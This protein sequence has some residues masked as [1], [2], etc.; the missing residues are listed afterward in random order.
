MVVRETSANLVELVVILCTRN[1]SHRHVLSAIR[2]DP[3]ATLQQ[4]R[5]LLQKEIASLPAQYSFLRLVGGHVVQI[6]AE[7]ESGPKAYKTKHFLPPVAAKPHLLL[8][9]RA[10]P[11]GPRNK[12]SQPAPA[13]EQLVEFCVRRLVEGKQYHHENEPGEIVGMIRLSPQA[14]LPQIR[15]DLATQLL[16]SNRY[17]FVRLLDGQVTLLTTAQEENAHPQTSLRASHFAPPYTARPEIV[18]LA[19]KTYVEG[20]VVPDETKTRELKSLASA[21]QSHSRVKGRNPRDMVKDKAAT[22]INAFLNS[23]GGVLLMGASDDGVIER[24]PIAGMKDN[25]EASLADRVALARTVKDDIRKLVDGICIQMDPAVEDDLVTTLFV[26]VRRKVSSKG[27]AAISSTE[28]V[29]QLAEEEIYNVIEIHVKPGRRS[30]YFL[31]KHS[32]EACE[33]RDGSTHCMDEGTIAEALHRGEEEGS[34]WR[35]GWRQLRSPFGFNKLMRRLSDPWAGREWLFASVRQQL[36]RQMQDPSSGNGEAGVCLTGSRG[37]GKTSFLSE[38]ALRPKYVTSMD[39]VAHHLCRADDPDTLNPGLFVHSLA[40][41]LARGF[42]EYRALMIDSFSEDSIGATML[43]ALR[44]EHCESDPDDAFLRGVLQPLWEIDA[45]RKSKNQSKLGFPLVILVDAVDE[46]LA[47]GATVKVRRRPGSATVAQLLERGLAQCGGLPSWIKLI[48]SCREEL[49]TVAGSIQ[50]L[51]SRL[52]IIDLDPDQSSPVQVQQAKDD[53]R[54]FIEAYIEST[55]MTTPFSGH[56]G[57]GFWRV[58]DAKFAAK[59]LDALRGRKCEQWQYEAKP[60]E[61]VSFDELVMPDLDFAQ[62]EELCTCSFILGK[63]LFKVEMK[64]LTLSNPRSGKEHKMRVV[65]DDSPE[66]SASDLVEPKDPSS[67]DASVK[68][69]CI[70][71]KEGDHHIMG[72][73]TKRVKDAQ[74][75]SSRATNDERENNIFDELASNSG[76]NYLYA[77]SVLE[78][79]SSGRL[80]WEQVPSLPRGLDHLYNDFFRQHLGGTGVETESGLAER[81][82]PVLRAVK[83]VLE[84]LLAAPKQGVAEREIAHAVVSGGACDPAAVAYCLRD[85]RWALDIDNSGPVA[86]YSLRHESIRAWLREEGNASMFG[87]REQH[88]HALLAASLLQRC[89]PQQVA[90]SRWI[91]SDTSSDATTSKSWYQWNGWVPNDSDEDIFNLVTHLALCDDYDSN[92]QVELLKT[93]GR[94]NLDCEYRGRTTALYSACSSGITKA[95]KLLLDAGADPNLSVRGRWPLHAAA[96][97]GFSETCE[98][99]LSTGAEVSV[100]TS[101]GRSALLNAT[102]RGSVSTVRCILD[103]AIKKGCHELVD[104]RQTDT[105]RTPLSIAA[106]DGYDE[107]I[108][109]LLDAN[110]AVYPADCRGRTPIYYGECKSS[111][112]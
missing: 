101:S 86:R 32:L 89:W 71:C 21:L 12:P 103:W 49:L 27:S 95:V 22:Y 38:L 104:W 84:V 73:C 52:A 36:F 3:S 47:V 51:V 74:E 60:G 96:S 39:V 4:L 63:Q 88:G 24:V 10:A 70:Y 64:E 76:G 102:C 57:R 83:P 58:E 53:I 45:R 69:S 50:S 46:S 109:L 80:K 100:R 5:S 107:I 9:A 14:S 6:T 94:A 30:I 87:L 81:R 75:H 67:V 108:H 62:K 93:V 28:E 31:D 106:E 19:Q 66:D 91:Q 43:R 77:R 17:R 112:R 99:L 56:C 98:L 13:E 41:M 65:V 61:W 25:V 18:V 1:G 110:A 15:Q 44:Q 2:C 8:Y 68:G 11:E 97:K 37:V 40:A 78:D 42:K 20:E 90:L 34:T 82:K 29:I 54:L 79:L 35:G 111:H 55:Q 16:L 85:I 26:P 105:G 92:E 33:R 23:S 48:V 72:D 7:Q 59:K